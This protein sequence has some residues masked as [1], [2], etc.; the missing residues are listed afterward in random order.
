MQQ[1]TSGH[2]QVQAK[3]VLLGLAAVGKSSLTLRCVRDIF[4]EYQEC[5]VGGMLAI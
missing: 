3:L 4:Q 1:S 5:T 2:R